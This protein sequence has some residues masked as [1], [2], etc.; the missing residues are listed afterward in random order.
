[1][2]LRSPR[3]ALPARLLMAGVVGLSALISAVPAEAIATGSTDAECAATALTEPVR[4]DAALDAGISAA[5]VR[6]QNDLTRAELSHLAEDG[7]SWLDDCG[8]VFVVDRAVPQAQ[9]EAVSSVSAEQVPADVLD[10]SSRPGSNRTVYLDFDGATYT[11]TR[12]SSGAEIAS[13]AYSIDADRTTFNETEQ[14]QI[15]LAWKVVAEDFA[16]FDVNVTTRRPD[17]SALTRSSSLDLTYGM[18]VVITP[19]NSVGA[20]CSC[21]G[22]AY[23]GVFGLV[24]GTA[25][26]PAWIFTNGS[27]TAGYNVGQVVSHEVGH[28]FG[29]NHDGTSRSSYYSGAK[30]WAPI[31]GAS[32]N[33]RASHWSRGEYADPTTPRTT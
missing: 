26:Q 4:L 20:G 24:G 5:T 17:P 28:T 22:V 12:W 25:Y 6:E 2:P 23:V 1:M 19:T 3:S 32:Y 7:T 21:G 13:P 18:P 10:L 16:A 8:Q 11:G 29:L 30:G 27:G 14:A 9:Q 15:F 33:K 31:M